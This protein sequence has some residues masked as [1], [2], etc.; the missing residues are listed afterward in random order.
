LVAISNKINQPTEANTN[1]AALDVKSIISG[2]TSWAFTTTGFSSTNATIRGA[3]AAIGIGR[4][5]T[6]SGSATTAGNL[7]TFLVTGFT[8]DGTTAT[9]T[10]SGFSG[11]AEA[12]LS[13]SVVSVR[14]LFFDD[15]TPEGSSSLGKYVTTPIKFANSSTYLRV[16]FAANIPSEATVK[17]FYKTS[18]GDTKQLAATKY[19]QMNPDSTIVKVENGNPAFSDID[20]TLTGLTPF[21]GLVVKI[22]LQS[23]NSCAVPII[24][25]LRVIACP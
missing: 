23:T 5:V 21:D 13:G 11:T 8:D 17:V 1:V 10:L 14:E 22:V 3:M 12:A 15:I 2:S 18:V 20:F 4:Y 16:R 19:T 24:K 6:I 25:D 9:I 7:G